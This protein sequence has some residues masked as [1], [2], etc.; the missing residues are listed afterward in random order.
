MHGLGN[1][2]ERAHRPRS[3]TWNKKKLGEVRGAALRRRSE[4][5]MKARQ[6]H[7]AGPDIVM[8]RQDQMRQV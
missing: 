4:A 6:E 8:R 7:V 2:C 5:R 3:N 1:Q